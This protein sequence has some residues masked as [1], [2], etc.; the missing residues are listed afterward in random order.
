MGECQIAICSG[1]VLPICGEERGIMPQQPLVKLV[2]LHKM[3][4]ENYH[5]C[6]SCT[7]FF[8]TLCAYAIVWIQSGKVITCRI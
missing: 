5:I 4:Y 7:K 6:K 3:C 2:N 1:A 8:T